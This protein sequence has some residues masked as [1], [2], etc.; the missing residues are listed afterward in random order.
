MKSQTDP[1]LKIN[2]G[3]R[4]IYEQFLAAVFFTITAFTLLRLLYA[5][6]MKD[7]KAFW[8]SLFECVKFGSIGIS[9]GI[10]FLKTKDVLLNTETHQ[11]VYQYTVG[12]FSKIVK[13]K[14][15]PFEYIAVF[16]KDDCL[17]ETNLWCEGNKHFQMFIFE[18]SKEAFNFGKIVAEKLNI[19]LLDA[20]E[21]GNNQWVERD[22]ITGEFKI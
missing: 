15:T 9:G 2:T 18:N 4:K 21:Y 14:S 19:D 16:K 5:L 1:I 17:F 3:N 22:E 10:F 6:W 20:T 8:D 7:S 13:V 11:I 12:P